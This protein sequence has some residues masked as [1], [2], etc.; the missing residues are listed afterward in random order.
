LTRRTS[1]DVYHQI[2]AE[3]LLSKRRW[4]VYKHLFRHGPLTQREVTDQISHKFAAERSYTPRFAE[5]EKMGVITSVGERACSITGRQVLIWDVTDC[6]PTKYEAP[7]TMPRK[8]VK[9]RMDAYREA[10]V[11]LWKDKRT[12]PFVKDVIRK[13]TEPFRKETTT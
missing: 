6:L 7:K 10:L 12:P 5:L 1:I 8:E 13:H 2:E 9:A 4:E 11:E 3:G